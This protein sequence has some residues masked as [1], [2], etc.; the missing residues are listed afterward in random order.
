MLKEAP[1][2]QSCA[3]KL[4][5]KEFESEGFDP[6]SCSLQI[7]R[8]GGAS[9]AAALE[10]PDRLFQ[11]QGGWRSV[12]AKKQLYLGN[13][14]LLA[15]SYEEEFMAQVEDGVLSGLL[16]VGDLHRH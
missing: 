9:S 5:K 11:K 8:S 14:G 6:S 12:Q 1:V 16:Y 3:S 2:S 4:A 15:A 13:T 7:P 10:N